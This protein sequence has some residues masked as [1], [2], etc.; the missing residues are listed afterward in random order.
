MPICVN[1]RSSAALTKQGRLSAWT[2]ERRAGRGLMSAFAVE[3]ETLAVDLEKSFERDPVFAL[4][5]HA[6]T[7]DT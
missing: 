2:P 4:A 6:L 1:L 5:T 7:E 3:T